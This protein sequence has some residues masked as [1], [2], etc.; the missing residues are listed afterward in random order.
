[1]AITICAAS[2]PLLR[3]LVREVRNRTTQRRYGYQQAAENMSASEDAFHRKSYGA[4]TLN[5]QSTV[6]VTADTG[7]T[8]GQW[9]L[10][11][12]PKS[13]PDTLNGDATAAS[14]NRILQTHQITVQYHQRDNVV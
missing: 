9:K 8:A 5:R 13:Y 11:F 14:D 2:V 7:H 3:V 10:D 4:G 1:M 12:D 6:V